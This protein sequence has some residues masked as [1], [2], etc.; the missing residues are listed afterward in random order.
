[1]LC[2]IAAIDS[3]P[4]PS[5]SSAMLDLLLVVLFMTFFKF[6]DIFRLGFPLFISVFRILLGRL[7]RVRAFETIIADPS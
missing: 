3:V 5:L 7:I 6:V 4:P 2:M 1:M